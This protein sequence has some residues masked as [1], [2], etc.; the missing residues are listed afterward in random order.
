MLV[1]SGCCVGHLK[2]PF[3]HFLATV[4]YCRML[5]LPLLPPHYVG[6]TSYVTLQLMLGEAR[7]NDGERQRDM[8]SLERSTHGKASAKVNSKIRY[9]IRKCKDHLS[10]NIYIQ[11]TL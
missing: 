2:S 9:R 10:I 5:L 4:Q 6:C 7:Q 11:S 8:H 1:W 3:Q